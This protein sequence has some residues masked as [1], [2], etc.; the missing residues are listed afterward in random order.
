MTS[1]SYI[2]MDVHE[3]SISIRGA[4][5]AKIPPRPEISIS[6]LGHSR[7]LWCRDISKV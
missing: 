2:G 5:R 7:R 3:E 6:K 1:T 4:I